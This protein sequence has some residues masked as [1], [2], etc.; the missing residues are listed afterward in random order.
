MDDAEKYII[1]HVPYSS[2]STQQVYYGVLSQSIKP[3][4]GFEYR[5]SVD[6]F[7]PCVACNDL[8]YQYK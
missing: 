2:I 5:Y 3:I 1:D 7:V 8:L 6:V 4:S